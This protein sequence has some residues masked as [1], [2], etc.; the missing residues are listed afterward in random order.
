VLSIVDDPYYFGQIAAANAFSDVYAMGGKPLTAM[1]SV[2]FPVKIMDKSVLKLILEGGLKKI[3][4]AGAILVGGH[5]VDDVELKYGLSVTGV[6][7]PQ[8]IITNAG[9]QVGD[10][11]ILTKPLGTGVIATAI[12]ANRAGEGAIRNLVEF[13]DAQTSGGLI[14][15]L[16]EKD[17]FTCLTKLH[18]EGV[19]EANIIG[20]VVKDHPKGKIRLVPC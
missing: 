10:T 20:K 13:F 11:L 6:V 15:T 3:K 2:C 16:P 18:A 12:K 8:Q 7:H 14:I 1:N 17:A 4:E 9:A 5:S 19:K